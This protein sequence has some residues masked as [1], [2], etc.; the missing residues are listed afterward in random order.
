M[1]YGFL[2]DVVVVLH[3]G[4]VAYVVAG[5]LAIWLGLLLGCRWV[6][7]VWFRA[8]HLLQLCGLDLGPAD[9]LLPPKPDNPEGFWEHPAFV[10]LNDD[11]LTAVGG[12][13]NVPP[14]TPVVGDADV[15]QPLRA[16]AAAL[17]GEIGLSEPWGWKDPRT[18]LTLPLWAA[19][20]PD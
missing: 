5:Q 4:Y 12:S 14:A 1:W 2:A 11:I 15:W 16:R 10:A 6:R 7:N 20:W 8:T 18:S 17:P 13:W 19:V 3:V 9:Q